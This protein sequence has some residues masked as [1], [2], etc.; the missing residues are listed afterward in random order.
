MA[1]PEYYLY[2]RRFCSCIFLARWVD[3][4]GSGGIL[5]MG[6]EHFIDNLV[7]ITMPMGSSSPSLC[8]MPF[9]HACHHA[10]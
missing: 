8:F 1:L 6:G 4:L 10:L 9:V 5:R 2:L 7:L 3:M